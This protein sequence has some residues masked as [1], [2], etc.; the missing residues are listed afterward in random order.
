VDLDDIV[1]ND[2]NSSTVRLDIIEWRSATNRVLYLCNEKGFPFSQVERRFHVG[3][4]QFSAYLKSEYVSTLQ[5]EGTIE[6]AEMNPIVTAVADN[7][8]TAIKDYF[9]ER[10]AQEARTVVEDWKQE[11]VYP[12]QGDPVTTIEQAERQVFDI[13]AV[14]VA[15]YL[16]DFS[17]APQKNKA[18]HH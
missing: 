8:L 7:A 14:N 17:T 3:Q 5:H 18:M 1:D 15:Q 2:G 13:V 12:Y 11:Q 6:L 4:F 9:R 16:P 10:A